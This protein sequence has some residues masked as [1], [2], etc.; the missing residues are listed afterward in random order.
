MFSEVFLTQVKKSLDNEQE[1]VIDN[2]LEKVK[3]I[4]SRIFRE[5][6]LPA[7]PVEEEFSISGFAVRLQQN[8]QK[9]IT[10]LKL[11]ECRI[12]YSFSVEPVTKGLILVDA[13]FA[14][15]APESNDLPIFDF[16][17]SNFEVESKL[18]VNGNTHRDILRLDA[19]E[20]FNLFT[21][22]QEH[23]QAQA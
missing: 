12:M 5:A 10:A 23:A 17:I 2:F 9:H 8:L 11:S 20:E 14:F 15:D 13:G 21:K 4:I 3:I 19:L 6:L 22:S 18:Y 16:K 1:E 7:I